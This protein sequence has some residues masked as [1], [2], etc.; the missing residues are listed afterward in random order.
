MGSEEEK[1]DERKKEK[2]E[3]CPSFEHTIDSK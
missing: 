2:K 3:E 1:R